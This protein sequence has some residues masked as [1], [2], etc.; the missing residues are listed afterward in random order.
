MQC[1]FF[2]HI[3]GF[4]FFCFHCLLDIRVLNQSWSPQ[5]SCRCT[6][7]SHKATVFKAAIST[8]FISLPRWI[9]LSLSDVQCPEPPLSVR[10]SALDNL[11]T[12]LE[13]FPH[14]PMC[15]QKG[16]DITVATAVT[17]ILFDCY[18]WSISYWFHQPLHTDSIKLL[19]SHNTLG[20]NAVNIVYYWYWSLCQILRND[21]SILTSLFLDSY[22]TLLHQLSKVRHLHDEMSRSVHAVKSWMNF[23]RVSDRRRKKLVHFNVA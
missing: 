9:L 18:L 5:W 14:D 15:V 2:V 19:M 12:V 20:V 22:Q 1:C 6:C 17:A 4:L 21:F 23:G 13:R 7:G 10:Y 16:T 11:A 8:K 3:S